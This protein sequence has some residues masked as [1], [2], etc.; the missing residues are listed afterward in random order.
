VPP[1]SDALQ[2]APGSLGTVRNAVLLLQ[3]LGEGTAY[4]H[5]TDLADQSGLSLPTVHRL[6]RSLVLAELVEQDPRS[7]RYGLGPELARL[8]HRYLA[9][10]P[11]A[12][13]AVRGTICPGI[14]DLLPPLKTRSDVLLGLLTGN[15]RAGAM[16]KLGP[17]G[18][19][20]FFA[21]GG[22]GDEH[23]DR[24]DVARAAVRSVER[25]LGRAVNPADVW[26]IGDTPLDVRCARAIGATAVAVATGWTGFDELA[27]SGADYT[28]HDLSDPREL[29]AAWG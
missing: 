7:S 17:Y 22:F 13:A 20:A 28:F 3:L 14:T 27:A 10:L 21:A 25:H 9:R 6:L 23:A 8:S 29:L 1:L 15:V 24:D 18:L 4:H 11:A 19:W 26:V 2:E 5:L 12:L 16:R